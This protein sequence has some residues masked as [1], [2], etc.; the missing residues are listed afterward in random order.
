MLM[1]SRFIDDV[2]VKL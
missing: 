2:T 1:E